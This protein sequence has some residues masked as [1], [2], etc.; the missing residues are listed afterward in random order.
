MTQAETFINTEEYWYIM[1]FIF[2]G[3]RS[4]GKSTVGKALA[5]K[6]NFEYF[7]F[8]E[9]VELKLNGIDQHIENNSVESYRIEEEK[10]LKKFVS[11]LPEKCVVSV[12]GGTIASQ[13]KDVSKRNVEILK[14]NGKIIYLSPSE[15]KKEAIEILF[16]REQKR[17]G[18]KDYSET[19]KLFEIRKPIYEKIFDVKIE[20]KN[21]SLSEI[22]DDILLKVSAE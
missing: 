3:P 2:I 22:V 14:K 15:D 18:D 6:L 17:K 19:V 10:I 12:G 8:D 9:Y 13:F 20:V 11:E 1:R 7:D 4:I 5:Q 16:E 21:K